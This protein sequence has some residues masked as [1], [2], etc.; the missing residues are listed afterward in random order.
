MNYVKK[1]VLDTGTLISA[2]IRIRSVPSL[3]FQ[4]A[5]RDYELCISRQTVAELETVLMRSKFDH[6]LDREQRAGF[7][8]DYKKIAVLYEVVDKVNDC[9]D[10]K[11]NMFLDLAL[12]AKAEVIIS[13]HPDL[14]E[15]NPYHNIAIMQPAVFLHDIEDI[16]NHLQRQGINETIV[17]EAIGWTRKK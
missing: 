8:A 3:A 4:K 6:Y 5:L 15:M 7:L 14:Y 11:D 16:R 10:P 17:T 12:S 2:A 9:R 1:A 13:S